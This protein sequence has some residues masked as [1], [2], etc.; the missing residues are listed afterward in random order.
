MSKHTLFDILNDLEKKTRGILENARRVLEK[1]KG[2]AAL[3]AWNTGFYLSG[4]TSKLKDPYFPFENA[5]DAWAR[6][7]AAM[8]ISYQGSVMN[9]DLCDRYVNR[10][11]IFL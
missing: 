9:L 7:F 1:E 10:D 5:V 8:N 3:D 6:S 11:L 2:P 4:E